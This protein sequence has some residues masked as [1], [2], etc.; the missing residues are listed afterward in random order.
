MASPQQCWM[1]FC[2]LLVFF[3]RD[4]QN[5]EISQYFQIFLQRT[6]RP[7]KIIEMKR[8]RELISQ[9]TRPMQ[10][11][12]QSLRPAKSSIL[13][14]RKLDFIQAEIRRLWRLPS[15]CKHIPTPNPV[16]IERK[17]LDT[18]ATN[19]YVVALK[20]DGIRYLLLLSRWPEVLGGACFGVMV[21]RAGCAFEVKL[22]ACAELFQGSLFDGE[23]VREKISEFNFRRQVYL[24]FDVVSAAGE[25]MINADYLTRL[26]L[27][28]TRFFIH[29]D[30]AMISR[31]AQWDAIAAEYAVGGQIVSGGNKRGLTFRPKNCSRVSELASMWRTLPGCPYPVDGLIFTPVDE[32]VKIGTHATMFKWKTCHTIDMRCFQKTKF[33]LWDDQ[34]NKE[35]DANRTV[36]TVNEMQLTLTIEDTSTLQRA[37]STSSSD[38]VA[39]F[40][41]IVKTAQS[42]VIATLKKTRPDKSNPNLV[43]T[44]ERTIVNILENISIEE[45]IGKFKF[46]QPSLSPK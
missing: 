13:D 41:L 8:K 40:G 23:L 28:Q 44:V 43:S 31:I 20:S 10:S 18:V 5:I 42:E 1:M 11:A 16:S 9:D 21:N 4:N 32:P 30:N 24:V 45:L 35:I 37:V 3:T 38:F 17:H 22:F 7:L 27:I 39:E 46:C 15:T 36:F 6:K 14:P 19:R 2:L 34:T 25:S 33:M 29:D 12:L 26:K